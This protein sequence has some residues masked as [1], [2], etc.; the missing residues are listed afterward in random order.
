MSHALTMYAALHRSVHVGEVV[1]HNYT[2]VS[3]AQRF[4][5]NAM[6][7]R[8]ALIVSQQSAL[9]VRV[10]CVPLVR[11]CWSAKGAGSACVAKT[12]VVAIASPVDIFFCAGCTV[13]V[14]DRRECRRQCL[15]CAVWTKRDK[16]THSGKP[17][18]GLVIAP[19][20]PY[21]RSRSSLR[22]HETLP[23][24]PENQ[25]I[26]SDED[27]IPDRSKFQRTRWSGLCE[28]GSPRSVL[29]QTSDAEPFELF[30]PQRPTVASVEMKD[31][32]PPVARCKGKPSASEAEVD[33]K[34]ESGTPSF[35]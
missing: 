31:T 8:S 16:D 33:N 7:Q 32:P 17:S 35:L 9:N 28:P 22:R 14:Y 15:E 20:T 25:G 21:K 6:Q 5:A 34:G 2:A 3:L 27:L 4:A 23:W 12:T 18:T 29:R 13:R 30:T 11:P 26:D 24:T 19:Q 10:H 1:A